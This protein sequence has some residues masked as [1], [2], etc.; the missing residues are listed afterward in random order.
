MPI[1]LQ[2]LGAAENVT[3]SRYLLTVNDTRILVDCGL[4]QERDYV[5]RNWDPFPI[6]PQRI[7]AV[8]LTHAHIDHCGYL[9]R[10][11]RDGFRGRIYGTA[12]TGAIA[13]IVLLDSAKLQTEDAEFKR[14]R[15]ARENRK[16]PRPEMPLYSTEDVEKCCSRFATVSYGEPVKV[17]KGIEAAFVDAG[18]I[19]GSA[20]IRVS[21]NERSIVFSGDIGRWNRPILNDPTPCPAADYVVMESTYGDRLHEQE[22]STENMLAAVVR[23]TAERGGNIVIPSFAIERAQEVLYYLNKLLQSNRI[24][25]LLVFV[26]SPMAA[27]V[28]QVFERHLDIQD[29]DMNK[30]VAARQSPFHFSGLRMVQSAEDSKAINHIKGT[31]VIMAGAGMCTGGRIKHHLVQNISRA[32]SS[33]LFVGYQAAGT[34]G[35]VILNGLTPVRILGQHL[36][37]R[38]RIAQIPGFSAHGDRNDLLRWVSGSAPFK[39]RHVFVTHGEPESARSFVE[40][41]AREKAF[42]A[43]APAFADEIT[44]D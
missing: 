34:L 8:L 5:Q 41:L 42:E 14:K 26:D 10:L 32:E 38:A 16:G 29:A 12:A 23:E 25:H 30:L 20:S 4:Y 44:L 18:H 15:H 2:F 22:D 28:T 40:T 1:R 27:S 21:T 11:V 35:R 39:P 19:L 31:V 9:P 37:V 33:I 13:K 36:P 24:P 43:S 7:D 3:G 17:G 6:P